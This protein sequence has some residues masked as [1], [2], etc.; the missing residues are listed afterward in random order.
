MRG[1]F[2]ILARCFIPLL[3][4]I[5]KA[6]GKHVMRAGAEFASDV[7]NGKLIGDVVIDSFREFFK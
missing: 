3:K 5:A 2:G 4:P 6:V 7:I 1:F